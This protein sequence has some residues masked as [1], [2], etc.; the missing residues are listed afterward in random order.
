MSHE[1]LPLV[2]MADDVDNIK[3]A[4]DESSR[5][6][7]RVII[8]CILFGI[9]LDTTLD[10]F[11]RAARRPKAIAVGVAAQFLILPAITFALTLL[12]G[13]GGSVALGMILVAC[14]P[15]GNVS[16]IVTHQARGDVALS[17]SMTAVSNLLAIVL[18]PL[19]FALWGN[20]HPTGGPMMRSIELDVVDMLVEVLV[21]IGLP[22]ALGIA[23]AHLWPRAASRSGKVVSPLAF[24]ALGVLIL[25]ALAKNL[26]LFLTWIGVVAVAVFLHDALALGLGYLIARAFRLPTD[27]TKAMT[28]E[29]G[30]RNAG[31][32]L[33]LV[34]SFFDGLGGMALVAAWW[35]IWDIIAALAVARVWRART[36]GRTRST[37]ALS[38]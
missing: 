5:M 2:V 3:I 25:L 17:V 34:F 8:A 12:L 13:V 29:V 28:F 6:L 18:M 1:L 20:L 36:S 37:A 26:D 22:F 27:A 32:G 4:F 35:G 11:R 14:C 19:N 33:L 24:A 16:N 38:P 9:A 30:V 23:A 15:P 10:D 7:L 21:V 31:L